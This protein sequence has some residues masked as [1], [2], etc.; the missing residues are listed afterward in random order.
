MIGV[1]DWATPFGE[2]AIK[3][4]AAKKSVTAESRFMVLEAVVVCVCRR[5]DS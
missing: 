3:N 1:G 4:V 2:N 5:L